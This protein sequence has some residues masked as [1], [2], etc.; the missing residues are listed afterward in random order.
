[1]IWDTN[2]ELVSRLKSECLDITK[3]YIRPIFFS[4]YLI[5]LYILEKV[6][7]TKD[8]WKVDSVSWILKHVEVGCRHVSYGTNV[9]PV[10]MNL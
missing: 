3:A 10:Q 1:M 7:Y 2:L 8:E 4:I 9:V 6:I 5:T